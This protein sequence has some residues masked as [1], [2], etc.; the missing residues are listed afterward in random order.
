M[1]KREKA[2][3][4]RGRGLAGS[5][6]VIVATWLGLVIAAA[7]G[8]SASTP[9]DIST[10]PRPEERTEKRAARQWRSLSDMDPVR[11]VAST[12]E[13]LWVGTG[14]GLLRYPLEGGSPLRLAG[15]TGPGEGRVITVSADSRGRLWALTESGLG[16]YESG[17]WTRP[18]G[19]VPH[20]GVVTSM[21]V[22]GDSTAWIGGS[23]GLISNGGGGW[24][25]WTVEDEVTGLAV[26][27]D[28]SI[29]VGTAKSGVWHVDSDRMISK[30]IQERGMPCSGVSSVIARRDDVWVVCRRD[31]GSILAR[32]DGTRWQG[33]TAAIAQHP[34]AL[35]QCRH[36][37]VLLTEEG[38]WQVS[39]LET[40]DGTIAAGDV[41]LKTI[42]LGGRA[43]PQRFKVRPSPAGRAVGEHQAAPLSSARP[44][45]PVASGGSSDDD[46]PPLFVL[47]GV[48]VAF[49]QDPTTVRCDDEGLWIGTKGLGVTRL[50]RGGQIT[51]YRTM[52]LVVTD[53]PF[54]VAADDEG[55]A[56][57][58]TR[59]LRAGV[60]ESSTDE[61]FEHAQ[62]ERD[63][64][65]GIQILSFGSRGSGAYALGRVRS[66]NVIRI[67]QL[68]RGEWVALISRELRF[69]PE[70]DEE[71][72]D[73]EQAPVPADPIVDFSFFE[74][75]PQGKFWIGLLWPRGGQGGELEPRGVL[76]VDL[77][78][79]EVTHHCS[80][81]RGPGAV[82][83]PDD[84]TVVDFTSN[85]D[86]WLGGLHG[87]IV[88]R[89]DGSIT[90]F[91][92]AN[93]LLGEI[94]NG[95]AIDDDDDVAWVATPEGL[96]H[97]EENSW[98]FFLDN[99]PENLNVV[100]LAVD[101]RGE[102]W[103]G[104]NR[105]A[106]HYDGHRWDVLTTRSGLISN[107]VRSVHVDAQNRIWFVTDAG[108][109]LLTR[110]PER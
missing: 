71:E 56:W 43:R 94:V 28:R 64:T 25:R 34:V 51:H 102:L 2:G 48:K 41:P 11:S 17:A 68:V 57:F 19:P 38:L 42:F 29:W 9:S 89:T 88:L 1:N 54:T 32:Y 4:R 45:A 14:G 108:I 93:G 95:L 40:P 36:G 3:A 62:V 72:A 44:F 66:A 60:L 78:Q 97:Y 77:E 50:A 15:T 33:F 10:S 67:Y 96:G 73:E 61:H 79:E 63:A 12:K 110:T 105:G 30:H 76:V 84:I 81:P 16:R 18:L 86:A 80:E 37:V 53:R 99:Q 91:R 22:Q 69:G 92:E 26:A 27:D 74:V 23:K 5:R 87:V 31:D 103:A 85:G 24:V 70:P 58:L 107:H 75:D 20:V 82:R 101:R 49:G 104:G 47:R 106:V 35:A 6:D 59:D 98:R 65:A 83:I 13:H 90:L 55:R 52:D 109:T 100:S 21:A 46:E 8:C 39:P 7:V